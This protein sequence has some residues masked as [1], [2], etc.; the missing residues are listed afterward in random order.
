MLYRAWKCI[1]VVPFDMAFQLYP[2]SV[3]WNSNKGAIC[4]HFLEKEASGSLTYISNILRQILNI[5]NN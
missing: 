3:L 5:L 2:V 1:T 4:P